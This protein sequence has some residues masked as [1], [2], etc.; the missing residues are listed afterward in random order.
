MLGEDSEED[1]RD[2]NIPGSSEGH[3]HMGIAMRWEEVGKTV[4]LLMQA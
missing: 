2:N 3:G 4:T 1:M